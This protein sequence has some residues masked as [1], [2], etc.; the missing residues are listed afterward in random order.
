[1]TI[2]NEQIMRSMAKMAVE[3]AAEIFAAMADESATALQGTPCTGADAMR[4][5]AAAI[6]S[7]SAKLY[8][9]G[10]PQ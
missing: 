2:P 1:M 10:E 9:P 8:P 6:R 7:T 5:F 4:A 3:Q